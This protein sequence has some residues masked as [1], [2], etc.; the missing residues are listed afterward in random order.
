MLDVLNTRV[1]W[2]VARIKCA[3][4]LQYLKYLIVIRLLLIRSRNSWIIFSIYSNG[5]KI[6]T[7]DL[8]KKIEQTVKLVILRCNLFSLCL[9]SGFQS[10]ISKMVF[11][12][13][14]YGH[15]IHFQFDMF[16]QSSYDVPPNKVTFVFLCSNWK[17]GSFLVFL[18]KHMA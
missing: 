16:E 3:N 5:D 7:S 10:P 2:P 8:L 15:L 11:I 18:S 17:F 14:Y 1:I 13:L 6:I 12:S 4:C 9:F